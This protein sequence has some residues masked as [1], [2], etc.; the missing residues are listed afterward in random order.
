LRAFE[1]TSPDL[2][3]AGPVFQVTVGPSRE[4]IEAMA[5]LGSATGRLLLI[6][7]VERSDHIRIISARTTTTHERKDH[8]E[9]I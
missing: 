5:S 3:T 1:S 4:M 9:N 6:V 7:F 8:E 2:F